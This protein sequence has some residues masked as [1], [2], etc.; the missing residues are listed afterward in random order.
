M[1]RS[2]GSFQ[3]WMPIRAGE[4]YICQ[5]RE[6]RE[7]GDTPLHPQRM[8]LS[9]SSEL[10]NRVPKVKRGEVVKLSLQT[11]PNLAGVKTAI[12]GGPALVTG[13]KAHEWNFGL[14]EIRES[15]RHPR[16]AVGWNDKFIFLV[17]V[18]GRQGGLSAG[19]TYA[20][21]ADYMVKLGCTEALNLDGGGS[22]TMWVYGQTVNSPSKGFDRGMANA[23]VL[24]QK[25]TNGSEK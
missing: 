2:G 11:S 25:E 4:T 10:L 20:E 23:L 21:I 13:G 12:G 6:V 8:V 15:M 14:L 3:P 22:A 1:G 18:D 9:L 5:V 24:I 16:T 7:N 17:E 19:M